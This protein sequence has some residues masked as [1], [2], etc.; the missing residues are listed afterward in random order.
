M[1]RLLNQSAIIIGGTE[2]VGYGIATKFM[3]EG[4]GVVII[5]SGEPPA[6]ETDEGL[7]L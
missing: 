6:S 3:R 2:A 1:S 4:A 7:S 5:D